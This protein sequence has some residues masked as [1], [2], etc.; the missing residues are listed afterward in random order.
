MVFLCTN[1]PLIS[2]YQMVKINRNIK[3]VTFLRS[4]CGIARGE[5][6]EDFSICKVLLPYINQMH[7]KLPLNIVFTLY[8]IFNDVSLTQN[9]Y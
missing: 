5:V 2:L 6:A 4:P 8:S 3:I 7:K 1:C 9:L